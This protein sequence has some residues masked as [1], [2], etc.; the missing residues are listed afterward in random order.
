MGNAGR[1]KA[2][3]QGRLKNREKMGREIAPLPQFRGS[4]SGPVP[5]AKQ[6]ALLEKA[7]KSASTMLEVVKEP[8]VSGQSLPPAPGN[9]PLTIYVFI[10]LKP[11][12]KVAV[13]LIPPGAM[14]FRVICMHC[15]VHQ[16]ACRNTT[17]SQR[18]DQINSN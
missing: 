1:D 9:P 4:Q 13:E 11:T 12:G 17:P 16:P 5:F 14:E 15:W 6:L 2:P 18:G 10:N 7:G 3:G 8:S